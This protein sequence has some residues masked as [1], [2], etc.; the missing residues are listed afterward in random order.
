MARMSNK[1]ALYSLL[2]AHSYR[3]LIFKELESYLNFQ[4]NKKQLCN[5]I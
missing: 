4:T 1:V 5:G 3:I 2:I